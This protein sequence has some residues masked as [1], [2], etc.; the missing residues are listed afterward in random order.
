MK[1]VQ[2]KDHTKFPTSTY[3]RRR[4]ARKS[5][6]Q[7][8]AAQDGFNSAGVKA[9]FRPALKWHDCLSIPIAGANKERKQ[10]IASAVRAVTHPG[11]EAIPRRRVPPAAAS[12]WGCGDDTGRTSEVTL[13]EGTH[14]RAGVA[15]PRPQMVLTRLLFVTRG[16]GEVDPGSANQEA[17]LPY[18]AF[19]G[20]SFAHEESGWSKN[21]KVGVN[22]QILRLQKNNLAFLHFRAFGK[23]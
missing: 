2:A 12:P 16:W 11:C 1:Q 3:T 6:C 5:F 15:P 23:I 4:Q 9:I 10:I 18:L 14:L 19:F 13:P 17:A 22:R 21:Y 7:A 20:F 8:A